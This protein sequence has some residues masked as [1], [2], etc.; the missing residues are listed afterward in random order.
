MLK[1]RDAAVNGGHSTASDAPSRDL[2]NIV[3]G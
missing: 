3:E 2:I 1:A